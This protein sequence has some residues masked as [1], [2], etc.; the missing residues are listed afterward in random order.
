M[1]V[2]KFNEINEDDALPKG[3]YQA[4]VKKV[5]RAVSKKDSLMAVVQYKISAPEQYKG[6]SITE[7]FT[8]GTPGGG[9]SD[10]WGWLEDDEIDSSVY[11]SKAIKKVL[12]AA[13]VASDQEAEWGE[14]LEALEGQELMIYVENEL[15][16]GKLRPN[17]KGH[18]AI[19]DRPAEITD[20]SAEPEVPK[21]RL[22]QR[23]TRQK[24]AVGK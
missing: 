4:S 5:K 10:Q 17:V 1:P 23:P 6:A 15:Y 14:V 18:Y 16:E 12:K 19:G 2:V 21:I 22:A 24:S 7:R 13:H 8:V 3:T 11:G 9:E 20:A